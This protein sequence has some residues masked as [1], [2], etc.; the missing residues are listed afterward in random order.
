L[1]K[2]EMERERE[3]ELAHMRAEGGAEGERNSSRL[4]AECR[5]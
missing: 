4:C 1:R 2:L 3:Q 5:A